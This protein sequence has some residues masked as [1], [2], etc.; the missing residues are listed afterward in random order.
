M[1]Q[2]N[3][4]V[5]VALLALASAAE[6]FGATLREVVK[7]ELIEPEA[8]PPAATPPCEPPKIEVQPTVPIVGDSGRAVT[9]V[10][11]GADKTFREM[12]LD[13]GAARLWAVEPWDESKIQSG[14]QFRSNPPAPAPQFSATTPA[15]GIGAPVL[16]FNDTVAG[17]VWLIDEVGNVTRNGARVYVASPGFEAETLARIG[18]R[19]WF[20]A[21]PS[22]WFAYDGQK[23][24]YQPD[25]PGASQ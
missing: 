3:R 5:S 19:L 25:P 21:K 2:S 13:S 6:A 15:P 12:A 17:D 11:E 7:R 9:P 16:E 24:V 10:G 14:S 4:A 8:R 23:P 20:R 1:T 18:D 22:R